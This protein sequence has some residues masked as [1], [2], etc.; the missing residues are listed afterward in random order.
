MYGV[1]NLSQGQQ[2]WRAGMLPFLRLIL[3]CFQNLSPFWSCWRFSFFIATFFNQPDNLVPCFLYVMLIYIQKFWWLTLIGKASAFSY[4]A[5]NISIYTLHKFVHFSVKDFEE[6]V[7]SS[8][9]AVGI[10]NCEPRI[11][12][13]SIPLE[14]RS[15]AATVHMDLYSDSSFKLLKMYCGFH[16]PM[17]HKSSHGLELVLKCSAPTLN[18]NLQ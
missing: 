18:Q 13:F 10:P 2:K 17:N 12:E 8:D 7:V 6:P 16:W 4:R 5:R 9:A 1:T 15:R 14:V 11:K 3:L